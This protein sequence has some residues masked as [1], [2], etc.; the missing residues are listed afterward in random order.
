MRSVPRPHRQIQNRNS[1]RHARLLVLG[2]LRARHN[3]RPVED[4]SVRLPAALQ[5]PYA[6]ED[7][8]LRLWNYWM[9]Y[10]DV[11]ALTGIPITT[12]SYIHIPMASSVDCLLSSL[13][14][15]FH[16]LGCARPNHHRR[17]RERLAGGRR[18]RA[19]NVAGCT[20]SP[21]EQQNGQFQLRKTTGVGLTFTASY[22]WSKM[23]SNIENP[24]D[25]YITSLS[26]VGA[27]WQTFNYPQNFVLS[28]TYD[29]P[30]GTN[31]RFLAGASPVTRAI[32]GNWSVNGITTIRSG[33]ALL[34]T[35]NGSLLPPQVDT[36][37]APANY[38]QGCGT[39]PHTLA[40]WFNVSC[41]SA[42]AADTFGNSTVGTIYG[43]GLTNWDFSVI[44]TAI[45]KERLHFRVEGDFLNLFKRSNLNKPGT[46]C[47]QTT[48]GKVCSSAGGFGQISGGN[49][50][51]REVQVGAKILF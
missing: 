23:L 2:T 6:P 40:A 5:S 43:P 4:H 46:T 9:D 38:M 47:Q 18:R 8:K 42:P 15:S 41:S 49:G 1:G 34:V 21:A 13:L 50:L 35:E 28:Y 12:I 14:R 37:N 27:G 36:G 30:F 17:T 19:N 7:S 10:S 45:F 24:I 33:G 25:P 44:K 16:R 20:V 22:T 32:V 11:D 31:K 39:N 3:G 51:P 29:L 26:L 48:P